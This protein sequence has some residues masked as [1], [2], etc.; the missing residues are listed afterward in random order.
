MFKEIP[1][2]RQRTCQI[3]VP[4]RLRKAPVR[5]DIVT[6]SGK[7]VSV[8]VSDGM[9]GKVAPFTLRELG[10]HTVAVKVDGVPV[11]DSPFYVEAIAEAPKVKAYG[12]GLKGGEALKPATFTIDAHNETTPGSLGVTVEGPVES[13]IDVRDNGDGTCCVSYI[14]ELPG[15]Y[16]IN[17][18]HADRPIADS[19]FLAN[20]TPSRKGPDYSQPPNVKAYGPGLVGGEC[21]KPALF[22]IDAREETFPGSLGVTVEGPKECVFN[23]TDNGDGTCSVSYVPE[24]PGTYKINISHAERPIHGSPFLPSIK[25]AANGLDVSGVKAYGPGLSPAGNDI[26]ACACSDRTATPLWLLCACFSLPAWLCSAWQ[27]VV[28]FPAGMALFG[29]A[30]CCLF[31]CRHGTV[32]FS[33]AGVDLCGMAQCCLFYC[34]HGSVRHGTVWFVLL[35]AWLCAVWHSVVF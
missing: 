23:C 33:S 12:P 35:Q 25:P 5:M 17:V 9:D 19:P 26:F 11:T 14:P 6:P 32:F 15:E 24:F 16:R 27:S 30:Q 28:C 29:M 10:P 21:C 2:G 31:S 18:S 1:V 34:R 13:K 20:I 4:P 8:P 3:K 7:T 22:T